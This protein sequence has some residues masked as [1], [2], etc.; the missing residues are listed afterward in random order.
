[1]NGLQQL[2]KVEPVATPGFPGEDFA[3][4]APVPP[5]PAAPARRRP[6]FVGPTLLIGAGL[7]LLLHNLGVVAWEAWANLWRLWPIVLIAV[8]LD[9]L[10]GRRSALGSALVAGAT[11]AALFGGI[12]LL[13][14]TATP[15]GQ[16]MIAQGLEGASRA[17]ITISPGVADLH[18][19]AADNAGTLIAGTVNRARGQTLEQDF[20]AYG[21]V[22]RYTLRSREERW[23]PVPGAI[24]GDDLAWDLQLTRE[25]PLFLAVNSG[26]GQTTLDLNGTRLTG[27]D[28]ASGVGKTTITLPAQGRFAATVNGGIGEIVVQ[29]PAGLAARIRVDTGIGNVTVPAGYTRQGDYYI[30]PGYEG[31]ANR[32]DLELHGGIGQFTVAEVAGR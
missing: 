25:V 19:T 16:E 4:P 5:R 9:I 30:S 29:I 6:G 14:A 18:V 3:Y 27:L 2:D 31:A 23:S 11:L 22:A 17:E 7:L 10:I 28:V 21:A 8:G 32:V 13:T 15:A 12:W 24:T 1:M 26:V 20:R